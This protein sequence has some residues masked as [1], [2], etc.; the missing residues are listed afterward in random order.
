MAAIVADSEGIDAVSL[1][2]IANDAGVK[3]PAL[4]RHVTGIEELWKLLARRARQMLA[5]QLRAAI[6]GVSRRNSVTAVAVAWR[7]F[8]HEHPGIYSS[9]D[10]VPS[11]GDPEIEKSLQQVIDALVDSLQGYSLTESQRGHC[12]R[13]LR[14]ALHGFCVLEK[15][16]GH[17]E[18]YAIDESLDNLVDLLCRGVE[19]LEGAPPALHSP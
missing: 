15:D 11:T 17:P 14:S 12:A 3:Q 18:P 1:Q 6:V 19:A 13:S 8:V 7:R 16:L 9:T 4:Y 10:R 5:E 2:R